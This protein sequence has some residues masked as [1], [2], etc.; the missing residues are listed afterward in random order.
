M[1]EKLNKINLQLFAGDGGD[2]GAGSDNGT[3]T[4]NA[5][6]ER[7]KE[8][9]RAVTK[10]LATQKANL[11][12]EHNA[13]MSEM[14]KKLKAFEEQGLT[15]AEKVAKRLQE[16]EN[17]EKDYKEKTQKL[18][19]GVSFSKMG[20]S[21]EDYNPIIDAYLKGDFISANA[22]ISEVITKRANEIASEKY[23]DAVSKLP[24]AN[25]GNNDGKGEM[26]KAKFDKLTYS[27]QMAELNMHPEYTK[28]L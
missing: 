21:E 28:F 2:A 8:I 10:A 13:Q 1:E 12:K 16:A 7:Q 11:E 19:L 20:V 22:K 25:Q 15:D 9:D 14:S 6:I 5:D 17:A 3:E 18:E 23:N 27:Q 24:G 4:A 26:T